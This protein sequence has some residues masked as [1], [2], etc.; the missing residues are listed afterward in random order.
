MPA[1]HFD[2]FEC[3]LGGFASP[4]RCRVRRCAWCWASCWRAT[5]ST[6]G[7]LYFQAT[8]GVAPRDHKF[9]AVARTSLVATAKRLKRMPGSMLEERASPSSRI[10]DIRWRRSD[11]K[12]VSLLANILGKQQAV[13]QGA[14]EAWQVDANG[15]VTEGTR[16]NAWI[17]HRGRRA[18]DPAARVTTS[19]PASCAA[20]SLGLLDGSRRAPSSSGPSA[21]PRPMMRARPSSPAAAASSCRSRPLDGPPVGMDGSGR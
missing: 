2:R 15:F 10:P 14:F 12:S 4:R 7:S 5:A 8:R 18:G 17:V 21:W 11:I 9:P 1:P 20:R 6:T 13:E 3:S 19:W 16:T